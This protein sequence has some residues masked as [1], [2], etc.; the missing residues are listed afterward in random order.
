MACVQCEDEGVSSPQQSEPPPSVSHTGDPAPDRSPTHK[1]EVDSTEVFRIDPLTLAA[2]A[3]LLFGA[4]FPVAGAPLLFWW[5]PA[6]PASAT[7]WV[8]RVRTTVDGRGLV[9]RRPFTT[10]SVAW[11]DVA[12]ITFPRFGFGKAALVDGGTVPLP[13]VTVDDL[14]RLSAASGGAVPDPTPPVPE[15]A[16]DPETE[17]DGDRSAEQKNSE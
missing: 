12:G 2:V 15:P 6:I 5:F 13:G 16:S 10:T 9:A 3:L 11:S 14:P 17:S 8:L 7:Y 4:S 1:S